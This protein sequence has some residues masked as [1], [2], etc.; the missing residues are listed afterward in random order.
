MPIL[1]NF[2][3]K[4]HLFLIFI[5]LSCENKNNEKNVQKISSDTVQVSKSV[6]PEPK[7]S[8]IEV[9]LE[10]K[11]LK[12]EIHTLQHTNLIVSYTES[13][14]KFNKIC[15]T[16]K[17][18]HYPVYERAKYIEKYS[19]HKDSLFVQRNG[20]DLKVKLK[21]GQA[22]I[23]TNDTA[24]HINYY[25][26]EYLKDIGY[27]VC[28]VSYYEGARYLMISDKTGEFFYMNGIPKISPDKKRIV[29]TPYDAG[30]Y[31]NDL[32]FNMWKINNQK[33]ELEFSYSFGNQLDNTQ[34]LDN[35]TI[36]FEMFAENHQMLECYDHK[37]G[38][39]YTSCKRVYEFKIIEP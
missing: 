2:L 21:N 27:Y 5:S 25:Y 15:D 12:F 6:K 31:F 7:F 36:R 30:S 29:T 26:R 35:S 38:E 37:N 24:Y 39:N 20:L 4:F 11:N 17:Y 22:K 33:I 23:I 1:R 3:T 34:W 28:F 19:L 13:E 9:V 8:L 18:K 10:S 32:S 14:K 16:I